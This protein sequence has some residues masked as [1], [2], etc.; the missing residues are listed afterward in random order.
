MP[1][2]CISFSNFCDSNLSLLNVILMYRGHKISAQTVMNKRAVKSYPAFRINT[3][4]QLSHY[5]SLEPHS[6]FVARSTDIGKQRKWAS[7]YVQHERDTS[8]SPTVSVSNSPRNT[9]LSNTPL[10]VI[11][12]NVMDMYTHFRI[13]LVE[14]RIMSLIINKYLFI[15]ALS[16]FTKHC[17]PLVNTF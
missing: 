11:V 3:S 5:H 4:G 8:C 10:S 6:E 17:N 15:F 13:C 7:L 1:Y 16:L 12:C 9:V 14:L 2:S